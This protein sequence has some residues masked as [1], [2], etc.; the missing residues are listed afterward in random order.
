MLTKELLPQ[1][2]MILNNYTLLIIIRHS[3]AVILSRW[4][5]ALL[6]GR[7][8]ELRPGFTD[9]PAQQPGSYSGSKVRQPQG[10][11]TAPSTL[12]PTTDPPV[13]D[14]RVSRC[15]TPPYESSDT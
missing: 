3:D 8:Y 9:R 4:A 6:L 14:W 2:H 11:T 7:E 5:S 1:I 10:D 13:M 12:L 15:S